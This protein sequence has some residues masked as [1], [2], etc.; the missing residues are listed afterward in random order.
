MT[1]RPTEPRTREM[2]L[3]MVPLSSPSSRDAFMPPPTLLLPPMSPW[4]EEA[5]MK[6]VGRG[7]RDASSR[8]K[9]EVGRGSLLETEGAVSTEP[10][11]E[12]TLRV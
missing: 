2:P 11:W 1:P 4:T 7:R 9:M 5:G 6:A 12:A 8:G 3:A 10:R